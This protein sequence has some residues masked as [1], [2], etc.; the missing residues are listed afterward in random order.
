MVTAR[1]GRP[2]KGGAKAAHQRFTT[3][4]CTSCGVERHRT[5]HKEDKVTYQ[6]RKCKGRVNR[7]IKALKLAKL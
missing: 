7:L 3:V 6:C 1:K 4:K 5:L 2:Y